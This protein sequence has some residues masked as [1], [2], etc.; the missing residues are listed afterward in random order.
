MYFVRTRNPQRARLEYHTQ[1]AKMSSDKFFD[2]TAGVY[3]YFSIS[4][5]IHGRGGL[6]YEYESVYPATT[7]REN[8]LM[9]NTRTTWR[10]II[11]YPG[12]NQSAVY[13]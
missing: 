7:G 3:F 11:I 9:F 5:C 1:L 4:I 8:T 2:L 13:T 6:P 12:I 10:S